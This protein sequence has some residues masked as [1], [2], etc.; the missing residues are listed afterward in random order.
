MTVKASQLPASLQW[1]RSFIQWV[2]GVGVVVLAISLMEPTHSTYRLYQAGGRENRIQITASQTVRRIW[3]IYIGLM[4]LSVLLFRA[5]GMPWWAALNHAMTAILTGGFGITDNSMGVYSSPIQLAVIVVMVLGAIAFS[6]HYNNIKRRRLSAIWLDHQN[7]V[8]A[9][10][11]IV[12]TG[13]VAFYKYAATGSFDWVDSA[14]QWA[15]A[16]TT[17][18]LSY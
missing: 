10:L 13:S 3:M 8:L 11:L 12:G 7:R 14:F 6:S 2:G 5:V 15:S 17:C 16:L 9:I 1:W 4:V 18:G